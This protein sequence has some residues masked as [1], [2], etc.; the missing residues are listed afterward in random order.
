MLLVLLSG[1]GVQ[2]THIRYLL[3]A[4]VQVT[5]GAEG[6]FSWKNILIPL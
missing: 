2:E 4:D 6:E 3:A 1:G 5:S